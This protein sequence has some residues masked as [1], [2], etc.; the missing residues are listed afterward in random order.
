MR[1]KTMRVF[2]MALVVACFHA[3]IVM[4]ESGWTVL[5][6]IT[7]AR[8]N[9]IWGIAED[10]IF[11]VGSGGVV[12]HYDGSEWS[13]RKLTYWAGISG[14]VSRDL[15]GVW[16]SDANNVFAVGNNRLVWYYNGSNWLCRES[17]LLANPLYGVW[18]RSPDEVF[19][20]GQLK[21]FIFWWHNVVYISPQEA[22][23]NPTTI[24]NT[25]YD[26]WGSGYPYRR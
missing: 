25:L 4:A 12:V 6:N 2:S 24:H 10:D 15:H 7:N 9:S 8:L 17:T 23:S 11:A 16:G 13:E 22:V 18:G 26:I 1:R 20:V 14:W 3:G 5:E 19:G 21:D